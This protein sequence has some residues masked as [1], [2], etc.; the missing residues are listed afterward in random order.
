MTTELKIPETRFDE[1]GR[2]YDPECGSDANWHRD[3]GQKDKQ[4]V[5]KMIIRDIRRGDFAQ[6]ED[7]WKLEM[8]TDESEEPARVVEFEK[9]SDV[10]DLEDAVIETV[11]LGAKDAGKRETTEYDVYVPYSGCMSVRISAL[12]EEEAFS[13]VYRWV[14]SGDNE[15]FD[16]AVDIGS[17]YEPKH[18][19]A[20]LAP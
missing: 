12:S 4:P 2:R 5:I 14:R 8:Y 3:F 13:V 15:F 7:T 16:K 17:E 20:A 9:A 1:W 18:I 10:D 19:D 11:R 6:T